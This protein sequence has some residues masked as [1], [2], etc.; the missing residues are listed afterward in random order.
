[1]VNEIQ[2]L[3]FFVIYEN[4]MYYYLVFYNVVDMNC[5]FFKMKMFWSFLCRVVQKFIG[6]MVFVEI[7]GFIIKIS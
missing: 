3:F 4:K 1:M 2:K 5:V 6:K 7:N